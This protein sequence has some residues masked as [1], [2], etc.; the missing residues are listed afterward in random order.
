MN[1]E[2][3][4]SRTVII[5]GDLVFKFPRILPFITAFKMTSSVA[6]GRGMKKLDEYTS[7]LFRNATK[8][9]IASVEDN[10]NEYLLWLKLKAVFL[11]KTHFSL[12]IVNIQVFIEGEH[13]TQEELWSIFSKIDKRTNYERRQVSTHCFDRKN[14]IKTKNGLMLVDGG[15]TNNKPGTPFDVFMLKWHEV[16]A[17]EFSKII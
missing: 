8:K 14:I 2:K 10:I 3:G 4:Q 11:P 13:P 7:K 6:K 9:F 17:E 16:V 5:L 1:I 12:G 15:D